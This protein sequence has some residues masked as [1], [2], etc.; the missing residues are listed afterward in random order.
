MPG[1]PHP[2]PFSS[3]KPY[4]SESP[5]S[6][7]TDHP[8]EQSPDYFQQVVGK[9]LPRHLNTI[10]RRWAS[11]ILVAVSGAFASGP[12]ASW[13]TL[14]PLLISEGVW[15]GPHQ[16]S[17]LSSVYS[18]AMGVS[19]IST[20]IAGMF[21]DVIGARSIGVYGALG[22]SICLILMAMAIKIPSLNNLLWFAYPAVNVFGMAN[23]MDAYAWLWLLPDDQ[24]TVSA[25]VG[26]IQCLSDSF[27]LI[28]VFLHTYYGLQLPIYFLMTALFSLVAGVIALVII[29]SHEDMRQIAD[30]V[31]R[32]QDITNASNSRGYGAIN[33]TMPTPQVTPFDRQMTPFESNKSAEDRNWWD[34]LSKAYSALY[35]ICIL[36][37]KVHPRISVLFFLY[38]MFQYMFAVYPILEMYPL[39]KDLMGRAG[40]VELVNIFGGTYACIGALCLLVSGRIVDRI[41]MSHAIGWLNVAILANSVLY[42]VPT[43]PAEVAAQVVLAVISNIWYV[44]VPRFCMAYG[45]PELFGTLMGIDGAFLGVGQIWLTRFGTWACSAIMLYLYRG[46]AQPAMPYLMTINLWAFCSI[47]TSFLLLGW[48]WYHPLP[49][50]GATTMAHVRNACAD[51]ASDGETLLL[52]SDLTK[53]HYQATNPEQLGSTASNPAHQ[54]RT[55]FASTCCG[56]CLQII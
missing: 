14:E 43:I 44:F 17:N 6:S 34:T 20:L 38:Q 41:G 16:T 21:Y 54:G 2:T 4:S 29:P 18:I 8:D 33:S 42:M 27:C 5:F 10:T 52:T 46:H 40:A 49:R 48:W 47:V 13:P 24:N 30:A 25:L 22:T 1:R 12:F 45:P 11:L 39:Y 50:S 53:D 26:A 9:E 15:A 35:D 3:E 55:A 7:V 56:G 31:I 37:S 51:S 28:A 32:H 19:M 36:Y 23:S